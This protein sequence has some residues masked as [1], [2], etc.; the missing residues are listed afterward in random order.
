MLFCVHCV[1][2][3]QLQLLTAIVKLF[4][5]KPTETQ[6]L[7]QQVLSLATQVREKMHTVTANRYVLILTVLLRMPSMSSSSSS[8]LRTDKA[9]WRRGETPR[10][11]NESSWF[12]TLETMW[13]FKFSKGN[14]D[15]RCQSASCISQILAEPRLTQFLTSLNHCSV[16][17]IGGAKED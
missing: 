7:V 9:C 2:K 12:I 17:L 14:L 13:T 5:K 15:L 8:I 6:E 10:N 16:A 1:L 3:V 11:W 4:L